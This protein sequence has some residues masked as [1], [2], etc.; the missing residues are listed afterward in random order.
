MKN[1]KAAK[2]TKASLEKNPRVALGFYRD[3]EDEV[4]MD[5]DEKAAN[6]AAAIIKAVK[7]NTPAAAKKVAAMSH[8]YEDNGANDTVARERIFI[9]YKTMGGSHS[10]LLWEAL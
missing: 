8:R 7:E 1:T 6:L 10:K 5:S 2:K 4:I 9:A 3:D